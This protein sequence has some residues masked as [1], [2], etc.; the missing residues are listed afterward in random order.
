MYMPTKTTK[1]KRTETGL[2]RTSFNLYPVA[3]K[4]LDYIVRQGKDRGV[5][6][7]QTQGIN[8]AIVAFARELGMK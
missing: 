1:R 2:E 7:D 8:D 3:A 5:R 4:A 6:Y